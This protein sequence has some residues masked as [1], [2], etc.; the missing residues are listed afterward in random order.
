MLY[1][2]RNSQ[3]TISN[4]LK[5]KITSKSTSC[6]NVS[7]TIRKC[8][9]IL[10]FYGPYA[11]RGYDPTQYQGVSFMEVVAMATGSRPEVPR[12][13][14]SIKWCIPTTDVLLPY[15]VWFINT[16]CL[17]LAIT[18]LKKNLSGSVLWNLNSKPY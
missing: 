8:S 11:Q 18:Y 2:F 6:Y 12:S 10:T 1:N 13:S 9:V 16:N 4:V 7:K 3:Q 5:N 17:L 14:F 15:I